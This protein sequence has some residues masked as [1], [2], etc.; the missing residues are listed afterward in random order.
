MT[1]ALSCAGFS[2]GI[3][4]D[5]QGNVDIVE[6][7]QTA[8]L[9]TTAGSL[10]PGF[11]AVTCQNSGP[12]AAPFAC[13]HI[14][15]AKVSGDGATVR[16]ATYLEGKSS[17]EAKAAA[18]DSAGDIYVLGTTSS[19]DFP[20][21]PGAYVPASACHSAVFVAMVSSDARSER[22]TYLPCG[23][24]QAGS[25]A[26]DPAGTVVVTG[27]TSAGVGVIY[28][29]SPDLST[30]LYSAP[31]SSGSFN[32]AAF[33][34]D[35]SSNLYILG[36]NSLNKLDNSGNLLWTFPMP[37]TAQSVAS[38]VT[39]DATGA[40]F[41]AGITP[42]PGNVP[43][44]PG[45]IHVTLSGAYV[46]QPYVAKVSADGSQLMYAALLPQKANVYLPLLAS[47]NS[48][49]E[50]LL[51]APAASGY[52]NTPND[53]TSKQACPTAPQ[54]Q[55][56]SYTFLKLAAD[57]SGPL[58]AAFL[59][60]VYDYI[61]NGAACQLGGD[62]GYPPL[63]LAVEPNGAVLLPSPTTPFEVFDTNAMPPPTVAA[64]VNA[65]SYLQGPIAPGEIISLFGAGMGP[66]QPAGVEMA[67]GVVSSD[68]AGVQVNIGGLPAPLLYVSD[69]QINAV[70]PFGV[71]GSAQSDIQVIRQGNPQMRVSLPVAQSALGV[72][73]LDWS[74]KGQAV[75]ENQD[76]GMNTAGNPAAPGSLVTV[77]TTGAGAMQPP[78]TDGSLGL[79]TSGPA[80][81]VAVKLD[82][83]AL[84]VVGES[85]VPGAVE[86]LVAI[87][88]QLPATMAPGVH[89][90]VVAVGMVSSQ[91]GVYINTK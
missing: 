73:S 64:V 42:A 55:F 68:L 76:G 78:V 43:A 80:Q 20:I 74:G 23:V 48:A 11:L 58:C 60:G 70:V 16:A 62:C 71:S 84:S 45:A 63:P 8:G 6:T 72:F 59:P 37:W 82:G 81:Q 90:L 3:A 40:A 18:V 27:A 44:T 65:A 56:G 38:S 9:L 79:G 14:Y 77:Y 89:Q 25:L 86:G 30:L 22:G 53:P 12:G 29:L 49:G 26:V 21:S 88:V 39:V 87:R 75:A 28:A 13:P 57:G 36:N 52:V 7:T 34:V 35:S 50:L 67:N 54:S 19:P 32:A 33:A 91:T 46:S 4:P 66:P 2:L 10:Q 15:V 69:G 83:Q 41:V 51:A 5:A 85:D 17:D 47:P 31:F 1:L 61:L 24:D